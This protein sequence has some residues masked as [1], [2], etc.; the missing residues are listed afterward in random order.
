MKFYVENSKKRKQV[1]DILNIF[2][3][4]EDLVFDDKADL[5]VYEGYF[6]YK[7]RKISY[8]NLK[9]DLYDFL[10]DL[11]GYKLSLIHI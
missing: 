8:D 7:D 10:V 11:T 3:D 1:Y 5:R 2:F 6:T 9:K 4:H